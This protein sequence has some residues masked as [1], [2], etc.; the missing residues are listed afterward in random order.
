MRKALFILGVQLLFAPLAHARQQ[1]VMFREGDAMRGPVRSVRIERAEISSRGGA[2]VEGP[3]RL[4]LTADYSPDGKRVGRESYR[5]DGSVRERSVEVFD[6]EGRQVEWS[7]HDAEGGLLDRRTYVRRGDERLEYGADGQLLERTVTTWNEARDGMVEVAVYDGAGALVRRDV[8]T[9]D[10]AAR[11][12]TW[13][14][15]GP[16]G[17]LVKQNVHSLNYG[18][19]GRIEQTDYNADGTV[20]GVRVASSDPAAGELEAVE[21]DAEG[22]PRRRTY[23]KREYDSQRNLMKLTDFRWDD[24]AE[25]FEPVAVTYYTVTYY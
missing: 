16:E 9:L 6:D 25:R 22:K 2:Q 5:E 12:S 21:R 14:S 1:A 11:K 3:R 18:G 19:P 24:A 13:R 23:E 10:K 20:A 17:R 4:V 7:R 8:N 15:Y